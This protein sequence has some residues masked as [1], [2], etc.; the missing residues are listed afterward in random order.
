MYVNLS[1]PGFSGRQDMPDD[2]DEWIGYDRMVEIVREH[3]DIEAQREQE[4]IWFLDVADE[5]RRA[6]AKFP[7]TDLLTTAFAEEAGELVKAILDNYNGKQSDLYTEAIQTIAMVVRLLE[8]GDPV[9]RLKPIL[10]QTV[11]V[12]AAQCGKTFMAIDQFEVQLERLY[13]GKIDHASFDRFRRDAE[14]IGQFE[15]VVSKEQ[16]KWI[17]HDGAGNEVEAPTEMPEIVEVVHGNIPESE[18]NQWVLHE[19]GAAFYI[20]PGEPGPEGM[21][22]TFACAAQILKTKHPPATHPIPSAGPVPDYTG[23]G[24]AWVPPTKPKRMADPASFGFGTYMDPLVAEAVRAS[25][26]SLAKPR[27]PTWPLP[28]SSLSLAAKVQEI[29][30]GSVSSVDRFA[31]CSKNEPCTP[32]GCEA[33]QGNWPRCPTEAGAVKAPPTDFPDQAYTS[34]ETAK[35]RELEASCQIFY[36]SQQRALAERNKWQETAEKAANFLEEYASRVPGISA[37]IEAL[38]SPTT[39]ETSKS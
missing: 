27:T 15:I 31:S 34:I 33:G 1:R 3:N 22:W 7:G 28:G 2:G 6:R 18:T 35:L 19:S 13:P 30:A 29:Q 20:E 12:N 9:H 39:N 14:R 25:D 17:F 38:R 11:M 37:V 36:E 32:A 23:E 16:A 8:E 10:E 24:S 21:S 4:P 5:L 26:C